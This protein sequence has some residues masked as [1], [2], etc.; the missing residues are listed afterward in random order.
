MKAGRKVTSGTK[1]RMGKIAVLDGG[2]ST[3]GGALVQGQVG[4]SPGTGAG[5]T[6]TGL[7]GTNTG[8]EVEI[9]GV[10]VEL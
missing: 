10:G 9:T 6:N 1:D 2:G 5:G 3:V 8:A 4:G 7:G